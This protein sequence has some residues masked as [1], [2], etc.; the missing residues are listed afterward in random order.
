MTFRSLRRSSQMNASM[1]IK[2][3]FIVVTLLQ[4]LPAASQ[5]TWAKL[6]NCT[7]STQ[8]ENPLIHACSFIRQLDLVI[9]VDESIYQDTLSNSENDRKDYVENYESF[10]QY[11][12]RWT[13][14][15]Y[16]PDGV[17]RM[18]IKTDW[19]NGFIVLQNYS[20]GNFKSDPDDELL[21]PYQKNATFKTYQR[22]DPSYRRDETGLGKVF[23]Y[24]SEIQKDRIENEKVVLGN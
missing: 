13:N 21:K 4:V 22:S 14:F 12:M 20:H 19:Q 6:N 11:F 3:A 16:G 18:I 8:M 7:N 15:S 1:S 10:L 9:V 17:R 23:R 2:V 5:K 24:I